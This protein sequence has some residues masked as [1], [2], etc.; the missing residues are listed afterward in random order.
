[1]DRIFDINTALLEIGR[2]LAYRVLRLRDG[3][4]VARHY[5]DAARI[6]ESDRGVFWCRLSHGSHNV[7]RLR[8]CATRTGS[9]RTEQHVRD[10]AVHGGAHQQRQQRS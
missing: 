8:Q 4:A 1:M 7:A 6:G 9:E 5:H 2:Q 10:R 3:E